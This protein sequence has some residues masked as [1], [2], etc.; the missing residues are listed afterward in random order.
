M[1]PVVVEFDRFEPKDSL[2]SRNELCQPGDVFTVHVRRSEKSNELERFSVT[3]TPQMR[4]LDAL[5][6][7]AESQAPDLAYRWLCGSKMCGTCAIRVN[8]KEALACWEAVSPD[9]VIEPLRN[10]PVVRDLVV[11]RKAFDEKIA[12]YEPWIVRD[13]GYAGFPEPLAHPEIKQ[14]SRAMDCIGCMACYSACPVIGLGDVTKFEGPGPLVQ[15]GQSALDPRNG[16]DKVSAMLQDVDAFSCV[17]CYKCEEVCPAKIPIVSM[18]IEPLKRKIAALHPEK[19]K[20]SLTFVEIVA[21]RGRIDP[22]ELVL[23]TQGLRALVNIPRIVRLLLRG[24]VKPLKT[25]FGRNPVAAKAARK[26]IFKD[27]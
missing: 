4:V 7:I 9:M 3:Y 5:N 25:L 19:A 24:K 2:A 20:H 14:A 13:E 18:V 22:T 1:S 15:L 8:G 10:L 27:Q 6:Q 17:S 12:G 11:D 23:R 26:A 16:D 21:R